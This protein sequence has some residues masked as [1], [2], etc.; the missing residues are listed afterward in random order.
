MKSLRFFGVNQKYFGVLGELFG[1]STGYWYLDHFEGRVASFTSMLCKQAE[2]LKQHRELSMSVRRT[3]KNNEEA[4]IR[5]RKIYQSLITGAGEAESRERESDV[6]DFHT[7]IP[8]ATKSSIEVQ[9]QHVYSHEKLRKVQAQFRGK[10][11]CITRS[12]HSALGYT[13]YEV[14]EQISNSTLNKHC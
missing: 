4:G 12:T 14:L 7:V 6:A 1:V 8:C 2:M 11:N 13:V 10:V 9:F 5:P 3:I